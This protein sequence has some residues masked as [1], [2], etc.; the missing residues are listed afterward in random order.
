[1]ALAVLGLVAASSIYTLF[2]ANRYAATQRV[3]SAAKALCQERIDQA[4]TDSLTS[5]NV[6]PLFGGAWP[7]PTAETLITTETVPLYVTEE[8]TDTALISGT[9]KTWVTAFT[10]VAANPAFVFARVRV[11]VEFWDH[12]RGV[13]NKKSTEVGA[14]PLF[15]EMTTLRSPD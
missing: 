9:R 6:A 4:L 7:L 12:G 8:N 14:Q 10:P 2:S 5:S 1:M 3:V 13:G 11:R 15:Y